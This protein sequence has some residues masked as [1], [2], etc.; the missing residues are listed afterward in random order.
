MWPCEE[1]CDAIEETNS[2]DLDDGFQVGV[3]NSR[4][5]TCRSPLDGGD[6]ERKEAT[7]YGDGL[8][9]A[10]STGQEQPLHFVELLTI[11]IGT[12]QRIRGRQNEVK[13]VI[14]SDSVPQQDQYRTR[15]SCWGRR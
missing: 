8:N 10:T 15:R 1:I 14:E 4:G 5:V 13:S 2:D 6:L 12:T 3:L 9:F 7:K 11:T